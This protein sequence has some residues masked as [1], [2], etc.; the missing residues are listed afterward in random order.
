MNL[1][2]FDRKVAFELIDEMRPLGTSWQGIADFLNAY[3]KLDLDESAYRK[4]YTEYSRGRVDQLPDKEFEKLMEE[5][6]RIALEK[7]YLSYEKSANFDAIRDITIKSILNEQAREA[8]NNEAKKLT[9]AD[10]VSAWDRTDEEEYVFSTSDFHYDGDEDMLLVL[11]RVYAHIRLKQQEHGF[12]KIKLIE[13]G[14]TF[15]GGTLRT[16]Q[17][18]AIK[19]GMVF[20]VI[21]IARAYANMINALSEYMLVDFYCVTSSNHT[22]LRPLGTKQ[23]QLVEEDLMHVFAETIELT[24]KYNNRVQVTKGKD[25]LIDVCGYN[26]FIA[27][28][29]LI[30][31][32]KEGYLQKV[33]YNRG[34]RISYGLFGHFHHYREITLYSGTHHNK[35]VFYAPSLNYKHGSYEGDLELSAKAGFIMQVFSRNRGHKYTEELF[36]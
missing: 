35:K 25:M 11:E 4:A 27:H 16:S 20:Q 7:R 5:K 22:Q 17:L 29:H 21:E 19:K 6:R 8:L 3:F 33:A 13:L 15:D 1:I 31:G 32:N 9:F 28:G 23:N 12:T 30:R 36:I 2:K 24:M 26:L 14:D 10:D 18:M 34:I